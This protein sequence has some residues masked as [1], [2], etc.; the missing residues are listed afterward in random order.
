MIASEVIEEVRRLVDPVALIGR[1]VKLARSGNGYSGSCPFHEGREASFRLYPKEK[2]FVCFGCGAS[3]D[4]AATTSPG[5]RM[6][7]RSRR[8]SPSSRRST[9]P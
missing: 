4:G 1:R 2:R 7:G 5:T 3:G 6:R 8:A 9:A